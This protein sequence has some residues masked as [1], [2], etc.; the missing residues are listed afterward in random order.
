MVIKY[1]LQKLKKQ[2]VIVGFR[3]MVDLSKIGYYWYKVEFMLKDY[4]KKKAMLEYFAAHPNIVHAYESTAKADLE[5]EMEVKSYEEF[6]SVLNDLRT[7][8]K[9]AIES[10]RHLLWFKEHKISFFPEN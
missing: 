8:F 5:L 7:K 10:Y 1:R 4:S 9:D 6:R 3:A 2:K